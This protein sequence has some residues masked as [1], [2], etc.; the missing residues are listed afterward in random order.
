[1]AHLLEFGDTL[2]GYD[3]WAS[4][5]DLEPNPLIA[6]TAWVLHSAPLGCA[7][8]DVLEL[9]CG[10]GRNVVRVIGEGA[11]SYTGVDGSAGMLTIAKNRFYDP[12]VTFQKADLLVPWTTP[13]QFDFA[14]VCLVLEHLTSLEVLAETLARSVRPGG[15]IRIVDLHPERVAAGSLAHFQDG[16]TE[17]QFASIAHPVGAIRETLEG[18]GFDVVRRDWLASDPMISA[19]PGIAKHR[20]LKAVLDIKATRRGRMARGSSGY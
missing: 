16:Y 20:G 7:D 17:V 18:A 8:C 4:T 3:R 6:A 15:R 1:M 9:G 19:V 10:T 14:L 11:R 2:H 13:W 12:R 5:Y